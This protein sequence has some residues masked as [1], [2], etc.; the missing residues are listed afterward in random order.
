MERGEDIRGSK[1]YIA[2]TTKLIEEYVK[3]K[4]TSKDGS[5]LVCEIAFYHRAKRIVRPKTKFM[6]SDDGEPIKLEVEE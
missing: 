3:F 1:W 2:Y 4:N 6:K 5:C